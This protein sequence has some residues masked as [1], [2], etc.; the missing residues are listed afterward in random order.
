[1]MLS[2]A[3]EKYRDKYGSSIAD[4]AQGFGSRRS[5]W[6]VCLWAVR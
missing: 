5:S 2:L 3:G 4:Y 1:M 6:T